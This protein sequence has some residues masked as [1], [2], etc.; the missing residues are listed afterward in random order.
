MGPSWI[1]EVTITLRC[2]VAWHLAAQHSCVLTDGLTVYIF[3]NLTM[4][5]M[6]T[7]LVV[8]RSLTALFFLKYSVES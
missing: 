4:G 5:D 3:M 8:C 6:K 2:H 7:E 1:R